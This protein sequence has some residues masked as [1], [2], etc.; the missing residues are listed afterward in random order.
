MSNITE[1]K[2]VE[3]RLKE[4]FECTQSPGW[5]HINDMFK[6]RILDL[7]NIDSLKSYSQE[8]LFKMMTIHANVADCLQE[9]LTQVEQEV[10]LQS[11]QT[12]DEIRVYG[13]DDF[14]G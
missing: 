10:D 6:A 2:Y 11:K 13:A 7:K 4:I 3:K 14:T 5:S 12:V 9:I 8:E 1:D